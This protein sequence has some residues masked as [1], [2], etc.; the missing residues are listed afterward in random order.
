MALQDILQKIL[1]EAAAEVVRIEDETRNEEQVLEA[2]SVEILA[3]EQAALEA[4]EAAALKT[5]E[6]KTSTM[7]RREIKKQ[8]L[9]AKHAVISD[10]LDKFV[11]HLENLGDDAYGKFIEKLCEG[12]AGGTGKLLAPKARVAVTKKFA[13]KGFDVVESDTVTGGFLAQL[14][15]AEI[16]NSFTNLV[17]SEFRNEIE[18]FFAQKLKLI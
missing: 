15:T 4:K 13:P 2:E 11:A 3:R 18:E 5:V 7:A 17:R 16:D 6:R 8:I 1:D 14:P 9:A 12:L 10:A